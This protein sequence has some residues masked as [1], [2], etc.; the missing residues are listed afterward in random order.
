MTAKPFR[1]PALLL[2]ALLGAGCASVPEQAPPA[3]ATA[4]P[5]ADELFARGDFRAAA[6]AYLALARNNGTA[7]NHYRLRAAEALREEGDLAGAAA[8]LEG[9]KRKR[10]PA[11]EGVRLD[12]L[13]AEIALSQ[14]DANQALA[15]LATPDTGLS[16]ELA[17]RRLELTARAQAMTGD[18]FGAARTRATLDRRLTGSDR[19]QNQKQILDALGGLGSQALKQRASVLPADDPLRPWLDLA[20]RKQ[21]EALPLSLGSPRRPVG[22][23]MH[24]AGGPQG[25][26]WVREG[27][28]EIHRIALLLPAAGA[29]SAA[30]TA[31]RDGFFAAHFSGHGEDTDAQVRVYDSGTTPEDALAAYRRA[32]ADGAERVVGPLARE[33]V[34]A[35]FEQ[36]ELPV[37][38]LALNQADSG[39]TPPAGSLA[40][41]LAP[42]IEGALA[43]EHMR[44]AG[45]G[46]AAV[47]AAS[48][49]WAERAVQSFRAQFESLGGRIAGTARLK[50]G[51]VRYASLIRQALGEPGNAQGR[52]LFLGL[53]PAQARLLMP[54]IRL[55]DASLPV[56]ATSHMYAGS[57]NPASDRDL[58]GIE[59]CDLPW[60]F[61]AST[62]LP[63]HDE[64]ARAI[65]SARGANGR[66]F[67]LG[68]DAYALLPYLDWLRGHPDDYLPGATGQLVVDPFGRVQRHLT[69]ARF[70]NGLAR[71]VAGSLSVSGTPAP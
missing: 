15:L 68:L 1:L 14:K 4:G 38:V 29:L 2:T 48:E 27:H 50:D 56:F 20:L 66:L 6:E 49:D 71:P 61:D 57:D 16:P 36:P 26:E 18:A 35:I 37:P 17:A 10:L 33:A 21:G 40:F 51:E 34:A 44:D 11:D 58:D 24:G 13:D 53:R 42:E 31:V 30:A 8:A 3:A 32:V 52:G 9:V 70:E 41:G 60:L 69:W 55:V 43:A 47:I 23:L 46:E 22:T 28:Y 39:T 67:A 7:R 19:G 12:L 25:R 63:R 62:G 54:Q 59:F 5:S 65:E 64:M 45:I